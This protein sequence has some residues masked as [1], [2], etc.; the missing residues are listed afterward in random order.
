MNTAARELVTPFAYYFSGNFTNKRLRQVC[1]VIPLESDTP[2][3]LRGI[4]VITNVKEVSLLLDLFSGPFRVFDGNVLPVVP[5]FT[6]E[7]GGSIKF[8][9]SLHEGVNLGR[10]R[11]RFVVQFLGVKVYRQ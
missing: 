5:E 6:Y 7:A 9:L 3:R 2:F 8:T 4:Q 1:T 10:K 11:P